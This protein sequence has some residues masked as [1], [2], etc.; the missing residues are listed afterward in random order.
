[1]N[2]SSSPAPVDRQL[3]RLGIY[4]ELEKRLREAENVQALAFQL[5]NETHGLAP[6]RQAVLWQDGISGSGRVIAVSG[7]PH[8]DAEAPFITWIKRVTSFLYAQ[9]EQAQNYTNR[10]ITASDLPPELAMDWNDWLPTHALW[11]PL[12]SSRFNLRAGL[13][14]ARD[15]AWIDSEK[16]VL[17]YLAGTAL[18]AWAALLADRKPLLPRLLWKKRRSWAA[19]LGILALLAV[20]PISQTS[21]VPAEIVA[22]D[23]VLIRAPLDGIIDRVDVEPNQVVQEGD[24]LFALDS[25]RIRSQLEVALNTRSVSETEYRQAQQQSLVDP[26]ANARLTL[27]KGQVDQHSAEV[28]YLQGLAERVEA[29]APRSGIVIFDDVNNWLGRPVGVGE[30]IMQI[31]SPQ[32]LKLE[33]QAPVADMINLQEGSRVRMFLNT[34]PHRPVEAMLSYYSYQANPT[35]DGILAYRLTADFEDGTR[36][37]RIGLQGTAKIYGDKT[38]LFMYLMRRPLR[39]IRQALG[40]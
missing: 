35:P 14:L 28:S 18:H 24:L 29:R 32:D 23:P 25:T 20:F 4:I 10:P 27:L 1:M 11:M 13:L 38:V 39:T 34:D 30:Q 19:A 8:P 36:P 15:K 16:L 22:R 17:G 40:L 33:M 7:L 2:S 9:S 5:V 21:L 31:A 6:Y 3:Q 12:T 26:R 37:L